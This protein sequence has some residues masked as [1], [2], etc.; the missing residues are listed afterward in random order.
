MLRSGRALLRISV[1]HLWVPAL[2][3]IFV[4]PLQERGAQEEAT[5]RRQVAAGFAAAPGR[6]LAGGGGGAM[7][8]GGGVRERGGLVSRRSGTAPASK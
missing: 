4:A 3:S 5:W 1:Q 2:H 8:F 7:D 6:H